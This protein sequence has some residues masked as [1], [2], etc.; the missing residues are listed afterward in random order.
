[1]SNVHANDPTFRSVVLSRENFEKNK[2]FFLE[3]C[4]NRCDWKIIFCSRIIDGLLAPLSH[5]D[6]GQ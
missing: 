6:V 2:E 1:L 3:T 5:Q 4:H